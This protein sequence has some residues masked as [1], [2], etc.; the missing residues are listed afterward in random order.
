MSVESLRAKKNKQARGLEPAELVL[1]NCHL[2]DV[3]CGE[4]KEA[5]VAI[6][7]D[8][9]VGIGD[10]SGVEEFDCRG[11]IVCPGFIEGHIHIESSM[12]SPKQFVDT[13]LPHG[14]TTVICDPHEIAN[15]AG[16][17]GVRYLLE[18][19]EGLSC[20]IFAMAPSCVPATHL[21]TSGADLLSQDLVEL[22]Q[23]PQ[24]LGLA[25]MMNFPGVLLQDK[26]VVAKLVA[27]GKLGVPI[28]GHAPGLS[29]K[30][31]QAYIG[32]GVMSDHECSTA[33]EALEKL[34]S[35]MYI[36]IREGST[37]KN[38]TALLPAVTEKNSHR[39]L[40]VT[41]DCHCDEL[42]KEGHLDRILRKAV[43]L[44]LDPITAI[45][46]VT[47]NVASFFGL[48]DRGGIAPGFR[49]DL[50]LFDDLQDIRVRTV[51][52]GGQQIGVRPGETELVSADLL[53]RYPRVF[54][55]VNVKTEGLSFE[56]PA[57]GKTARII[58]VKKDELITDSV[59]CDVKIIDGMAVAD[60]DRDIAKLAVI[61]RHH[62]T[63][64]RG[65]G[66][67]QGLGLKKGALAST[68]GHDS[69]NITVVG[70]NDYDM[71]LVVKTII[72]QG[73]GLA[74][75]C[76]GEVKARLVLDVAGL[77]SSAAPRVLAANFSKLLEAALELGVTVDDPFMLMSFMAL[78]VIPHLKMTDLGLVDVD[79][80]CLTDQWL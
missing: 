69:H 33:A 74:V 8:T 20:S 65:I 28:D 71:H 77:M 78:P 49:A 24:A 51:Y 17:T 59:E 40:L 36:F 7:G 13:V 1:K 27:A 68:V 29:G 76:D 52:S 26:E 4:L 47:I 15:V 62:C 53:E 19:S 45:R 43:R 58:R 75:V 44:G 34:S 38:L 72:A 42:L 2:V 67:V 9:I 5:D 3:F 73:G 22:M 55:S 57:N 60:K 18:E 46:M 25:E 30:D 56:I 35:G 21:E 48:R 66:F 6:C 39:C 16:I 41:D 31:L 70:A 37:A 50:V 54:D 11:G 79:S 10:Y 14:T 61:E 80:F 64:N 63:G 12:L 32:N 23:L